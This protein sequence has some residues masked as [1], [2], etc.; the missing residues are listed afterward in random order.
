M[1]GQVS[2]EPWRLPRTRLADDGITVTGRLEKVDLHNR[3]F[4]LRDDVGNT[5]I[6]DDVVNADHVGPL[7]G[8]RTIASGTAINHTDGR[9]RSLTEVT[10]AAA[11]FPPEWIVGGHG[12]VDSA[13]HRQH[14]PRRAGCALA[15]TPRRSHC[16]HRGTNPRRSTGWTAD[17][18]LG[19][20][21]PGSGARAA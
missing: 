14:T 6:L 4:R 3:K 10:V 19:A 11:S 21:T 5:I 2:L 13:V 7:V 18:R 17:R 1:R 15:G 20:G 8:Q 12:R 16:G 9:L